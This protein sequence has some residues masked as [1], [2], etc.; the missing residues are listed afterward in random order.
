[1]VLIVDVVEAGIGEIEFANQQRDFGMVRQFEERLDLV[2][3]LFQCVHVVPLKVVHVHFKHAIRVR[4]RIVLIRARLQVLQ[5]RRMVR[6]QSVELRE[7]RERLALQSVF[8]GIL[9]YV[10]VGPYTYTNIIVFVAAN[11]ISIPI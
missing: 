3:D 11:T 1:M 2:I 7:D 9:V 10:K 8:S 4:L 5:E 6:R